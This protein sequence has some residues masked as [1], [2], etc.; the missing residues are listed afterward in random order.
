MICTYLRSLFRS[1]EPLLPPQCINQLSWQCLDIFSCRNSSGKFYD[2]ID[3]HVPHIIMWFAKI[4]KTLMFVRV[5][6]PGGG[7]NRYPHKISW[8]HLTDRWS[9]GVLIW[10]KDQKVYRYLIVLD[11]EEKI[12]RLS[13]WPPTLK[14][15]GLENCF[16]M[17]RAQFSRNVRS[18]ADRRRVFI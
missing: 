18:T 15:Y 10:G 13:H 9:Q 8:P 16:L 17:I 6:F 1:T 2:I 4:H 11:E 3:R 14:P 5:W 7:V 12:K